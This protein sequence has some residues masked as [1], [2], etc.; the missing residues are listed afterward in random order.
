MGA[1]LAKEVLL[2]CG[3]D[4]YLVYWS[5]IDMGH[6]SY[7]ALFIRTAKQQMAAYRTVAPEPLQLVYWLLFGSGEWSCRIEG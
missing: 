4:C 7:R 3:L 5:V 2:L 1:A 6:W